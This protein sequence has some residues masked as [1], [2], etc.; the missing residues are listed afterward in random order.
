MRSRQIRRFSFQ[1][2]KSAEFEL[3]VDVWDE[4]DALVKMTHGAGHDSEALADVLESL[5]EK[6]C[7]ISI[8]QLENAFEWMWTALHDA[9]QQID[10][11]MA[12]L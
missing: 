9:N 3:S 2:T 7:D 1:E 12:D 4:Y 8:V 6:L 10:E 5:E 11:L